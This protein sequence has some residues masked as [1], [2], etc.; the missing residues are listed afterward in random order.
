MYSRM[1]WTILWR[2][3]MFRRWPAA[4]V[5][6]AVWSLLLATLTRSPT[7][8]S[9]SSPRSDLELRHVDPRLSGGDLLVGSAQLRDLA[10]ARR[11]GLAAQLEAWS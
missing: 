2:V 5:D 4:R 8:K 11:D 3:M 10:R 6:V 9:G 1:T 7:S